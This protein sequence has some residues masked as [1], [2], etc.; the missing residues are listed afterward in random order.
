MGNVLKWTSGV[1]S[2]K[3]KEPPNNCIPSSANISMNKKS[4]NNREIID[5]I[6]LNREIT[7]FLKD[8]QYLKKI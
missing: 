6:E 2:G 7:K 1:P 4:R 8:D 5:L 3:L